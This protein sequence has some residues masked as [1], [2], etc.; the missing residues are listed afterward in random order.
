MSGCDTS[1][2]AQENLRT[3]TAKPGSPVYFSASSSSSHDMGA[4]FRSAPLKLQEAEQKA[5]PS[6]GNPG[7][8]GCGMPYINYPSS[9]SPETP[10]RRDS[11]GEALHR[12]RKALQRW[13]KTLRCVLGLGGVAYVILISAWDFFCIPE[14][15]GK[16]SSP[17]PLFLFREKKYINCMHFLVYI[18]TN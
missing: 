12:W 8:I 1:L 3:A 17:A 4:G 2:R 18:Y 9:L 14:R 10:R 7:G 13:R 15:S 6:P 5:P 16:F 11:V